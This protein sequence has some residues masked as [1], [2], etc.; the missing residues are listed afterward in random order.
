MTADSRRLRVGLLFGGRSGEH[1]VSIRSAL[2]VLEAIDREKYEV[3]PIGIT[4]EGRWLIATDPRQLIAGGAVAGQGTMVAVVPEPGDRKLT[5]V[6]A[7]AG[8][9]VGQVDVVFPLLHG[10]YGEDGTVQGLL[11]LANVPY[12]GAG[13]LGSACGMD[14]GVMKRLFQAANLPVLDWVAIRKVDW[15]R[16]PA[17]TIRE[18]ADRLG[19][20]NF[21]KPAN[22]GS[23]V[24]ISKVRHPDEF[25]DALELAFSYDIKVVVERAAI[26]CREVECAVLGNDEPVAS[27]VGELV[28]RREFYDY[29]AKYVSNDTDLYIPADLPEPVGTRVQALA[30]AAFQAV[31]CAGLGRVDFFVQRDTGAISVNE[32]NTL[33]GFTSI[34]MYPKLWEASGIG[35]RELIDRLIQLAFERH[36]ERSALRIS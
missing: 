13:V 15:R 23:S 7:T 4:R 8:R 2:S 29:T 16:D 26:D 31:E 18:L 32:I 20:P 10:P 5:T 34:S 19:Y 28:P 9:A 3:V 11:E 14:K 21:V 24:G 12:V 30:V 22:L 17:G 36:A 33:P 27:V 25:H 6:D 35:Y 1:E